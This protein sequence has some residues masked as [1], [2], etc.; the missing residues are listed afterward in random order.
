MSDH[1]RFPTVTQIAALPPQ[2]SKVH[3]LFANVYVF[4][5]HQD[6]LIATSKVQEWVLRT[7]LILIVIDICVIWTGEHYFVTLFL[8]SW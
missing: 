1:S 7:W 2:K 8:F 4:M 3:S 5:F 6:G